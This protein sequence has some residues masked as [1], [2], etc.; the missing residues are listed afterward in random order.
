MTLNA[1]YPVLAVEDVPAAARFFLDHFPVEPTFESDW[2]VSLRTTNESRFQLAVM[3]YDHPSL[4]DG[5][6][7]AA[8]GVLINLE[9]SDA[10]AEYARL[11]KAG[12]AIERDIRSEEW[13]QRHFIVA[14]PGKILVDVI[15]II[16]PSEAFLAQYAQDARDELFDS[17]SGPSAPGA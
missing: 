1:L 17:A 14:G 6:R 13:G 12:V 3:A 9:V 15:Q 10:D 7:L 2:Y 8:Q 4:P 5:Y 16:P 11:R